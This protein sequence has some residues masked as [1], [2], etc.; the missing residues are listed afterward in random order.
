MAFRSDAGQIVLIGGSSVFAPA[1]DASLQSGVMRDTWEAPDAA[2]VPG[3]GPGLAPVT[4]QSLVITPTQMKRPCTVNG[5][6]TLSG[7]APAGGATVQ[8]T[9]MPQDGMSDPSVFVPGSQVTI[10]GNNNS[11]GFGIQCPPPPALFWSS[12]QLVV[13]AKLGASSRSANVTF[14]P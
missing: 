14:T 8:L 6:I 12:V 9:K 3:P 10:P 7:P 4:I 1:Q 11:G 13:T 2:V 5:M